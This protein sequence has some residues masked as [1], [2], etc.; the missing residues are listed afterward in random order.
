MYNLLIKWNSQSGNAVSYDV[1]ESVNGGD[2]TDW[3]ADTADTQRNLDVPYPLFDDAGSDYQ[4]RARAKDAAGNAG[5]WSEPME[6]N[7]ATPV[8]INEAAYAGTDA[9]DDDQWIELYNKSDASVD[10]TGWTLGGASLNGA[11]PAGGYFLLARN[12]DALSDTVPDQIFADALDSRHLTLRAPNGRYVDE[13]YSSLLN[14]PAAFVSGGHHCGMERVSA[15][16]FGNADQNWLLND[17]KTENG[18]DK[19]GNVIC[20]TPGKPNSVAGRYTYNTLAFTADRTLPAAL[21][22]YLFK[23]TVSVQKGVTLSLEPGDVVKFYDANATLNVQGTLAAQGSKEQPIV[24]T[25]FHD[26]D[27]GGSGEGTDNDYWR[28][29]YFTADSQ[30]SVLSHVLVRYG[31]TTYGS[32]NPMGG[33]ALWAQDS[34]IALTDSTIEHNRNCPLELENSQSVISGDTFS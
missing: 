26:A 7:T 33:S 34:S 6:I 8:V 32:P 22:P 29:I 5:D 1:Q 14:N 25:S 12:K 15:Y 31:G 18:L 19:N 27:Y 2:W 20:G 30:N 10:L 21:S 11:I 13:F 9:S 3:V 4:F 23:D 17:G 28:G 16:A 24:F